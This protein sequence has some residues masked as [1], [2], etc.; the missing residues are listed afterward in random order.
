MGMW[1]S[2]DESDEVV[3]GP[4]WGSEMYVAYRVMVTFK[5]TW[6]S[7]ETLGDDPDDALSGLRL[8]PK[9]V[10]HSDK[11]FAPVRKQLVTVLYD[12]RPEAETTKSIV[13]ITPQRLQRTPGALECDHDSVC[14]VHLRTP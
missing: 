7:L 2:G 6:R 10:V 8:W 14:N 4:S 1:D 9:V 11:L 13:G 5:C 3:P 12:L